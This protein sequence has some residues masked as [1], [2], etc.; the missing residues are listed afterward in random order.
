MDASVSRPSFLV[1]TGGE[2]SFLL[3]F[4]L[5]GSLG[6]C[7]MVVEGTRLLDLLFAEPFFSKHLETC[8]GGCH[9]Q[10]CHGY[11]HA[12]LWLPQFTQALSPH[13]S[14]GDGF[15]CG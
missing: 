9:S 4:L 8:L 13:P 3:F 2:F 5:F 7:L 15:E 14:I 10:G 6:W 11:L 12:Y 1:M